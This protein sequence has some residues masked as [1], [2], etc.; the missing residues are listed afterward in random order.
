MVPVMLRNEFIL[1]C[2]CTY[3]RPK[4]LGTLLAACDRLIAPDGT[5]VEVLIVDNDEKESAREVVES[6]A[7]QAS[8]PVHYRVQPERGIANARNKVLD[9][10]CALAADYIAFIDDDE[11]MQ[12]DWLVHLYARMNETGADAVGG[13]VFWDLPED[14]PG[15]AHALPTSP[16]YTTL[17]RAKT[18]AREFPSTNNVLIRAALF[19]YWGLRFDPRFGLTAGEDLDFF[20]RA[21]QAGAVYAFTDKAAVMEHVP[22]SRLTLQWR[23]ARVTSWSSINAIQYREKRGLLRAIIYLG[24]RIVQGF[25]AG[26][27]MI[28]ASPL[29]GPRQLLRGLKHLAGAFGKIKGLL[30][31]PVAEYEKTH[32]Y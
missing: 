10:A 17:Y 30:D 31:S 4:M 11:Y 9:E 19:R 1:V 16:K 13:P 27:V 14:A 21:K 8:I 6:F 28:V 18:K 29:L 23:F 25:I 22:P 12:P 26:P 3:L 7:A 24:P 20:I 32:G 5:R 2:A 15:W